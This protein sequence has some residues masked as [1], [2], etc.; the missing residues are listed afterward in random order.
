VLDALVELGEHADDEGTRVL[1]EPLSRYEDYMLNRL[2]QRVGLAETTRRGS[3]K[4]MGA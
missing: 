2:D 4:V 1:L 3:V